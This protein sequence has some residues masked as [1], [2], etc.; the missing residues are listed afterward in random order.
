MRCSFV[1][2]VPKYLNCATFSD[3]NSTGCLNTRCRET[4]WF[5]TLEVYAGRPVT[6]P[7]LN[8]WIFIYLT[9]QL[10]VRPIPWTEEVERH[11][12]TEGTNIWTA[13]PCS[14]LRFNRR[15]GGTYRLRLHGR[16]PSRFPPA[17]KLVSYCALWTLKMKAVYFSETLV[18]FQRTIR[19]CITAVRTSNPTIWTLVEFQ[20]F[21]KY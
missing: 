10:C 21:Q 8:N 1:I 7:H 20:I 12:N 6:S 9:D 5:P 14:V 4:L 18:D 3:C 16:V 2:V 13:M 15:F 11:M 17:F 19:R